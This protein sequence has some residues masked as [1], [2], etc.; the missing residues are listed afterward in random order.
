MMEHDQ[1]PTVPGPLSVPTEEQLAALA[2][3][4]AVSGRPP[5]PASVT[6]LLMH[7]SAMKFCDEATRE[8]LLLIRE[9]RRFNP[10]TGK[11]NATKETK[12]AVPKHPMFRTVAF[13]REF[14]NDPD[15]TA[16]ARVTLASRIGSMMQAIEKVVQ[17]TQSGFVNNQMT[18]VRLIQQGSK[19]DLDDASLTEDIEDKTALEDAELIEQAKALGISGSELEKFL[20]DSKYNTASVDDEEDEDDDDAQAAC[21]P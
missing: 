15:L 7:P 6:D 1:H 19:K 17:E 16:N 3:E 21:R 12:E 2:E 9:F 14:M 13:L 11:L 18:M 4:R 5:T 8:K 20:T 10:K